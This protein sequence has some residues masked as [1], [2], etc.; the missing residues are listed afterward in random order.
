MG[1]EDKNSWRARGKE[2]AGSNPAPLTFSSIY[3]YDRLDAPAMAPN[4]VLIMRT[5]NVVLR[6]IGLALALLLPGCPCVQEIPAE[7]T[8]FS[9]RYGYFVAGPWGFEGALT[10]ENLGDLEWTLEGSFLFPTSGY[11]VLTP[12]VDIAESYPEQVTIRIRVLTPD[13]DAAVL[14]VLTEVPITLTIQASDLALFDISFICPSREPVLPERD[15]LERS[16]RL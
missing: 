2:V 10:K 14:Q 7:L 12:Q 16:A 1:V 9:G 8:P 5:R 3:L 4:G 15:D 11:R 6:I 13:P